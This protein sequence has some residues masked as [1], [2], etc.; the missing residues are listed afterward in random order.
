KRPARQTSA[1]QAI[2]TIDRGL[3]IGFDHPARDQILEMRKNGKPGG[4][5]QPWIDADINRAND[6]RNIRRTLRQAMQYRIL[7]GL[8]MKNVVTDEARRVGNGRTV[9]RQVNSLRAS[10]EL[11]Q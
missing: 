5:R 8:A 2:D 11:R 6:G 1:G 9:S 3:T 10:R 7:A 4:T